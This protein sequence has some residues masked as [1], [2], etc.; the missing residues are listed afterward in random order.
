MFAIDS[1]FLR[2]DDAGDAV[3]I[4]RQEFAILSPRRCSSKAML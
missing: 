1:V 4:V 2:E 3:C